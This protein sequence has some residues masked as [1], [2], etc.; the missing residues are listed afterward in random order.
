M[1]NKIVSADAAAA[2]IEDGY[3]VT[4]SGFVGIGV[5]ETLLKAVARRFESTNSP[6]HLTLFFSAGQGD[7]RDR[8]LNHL[9]ADG[10]L[11]RVI[12]GHWGL[13]PKVG[14]L[15]AEGRI[16]AYNLPQGVISQMF[17]DIAAGKPGTL[18]RVGLETFVDPRKGGGKLNDITIGDVVRLMEIDGEECLFYPAIPIDVA[19]LRGTTADTA[20]NVTMENEALTIDNLA[21]AMAAK[22]SGGMVI[23][24]V[25]QVVARG[26]LNPRDV[27]IP[28]ALV[29]AV[30]LAEPGDHMQTFRTPFSPAFT[31]RYRMP[32]EAAEAMPLDVRKVI[33]RRAAFELPVNGIV[34]LGIGMPEGVAAVAA[35]ER[36]LEHLTLTAEPG[37]IGG[38]PASGLDFGA[39]VNTDAVIAQNQQF[40]FY[41]GGGLDI[42]ILGMAEV[43]ARGS[44]NVSKFGPRLAGAGGF[45][46]ISQNARKVVFTGSFTS[47]AL[48]LSVENGALSIRSEGKVGKFVEQ[49]QHETFSGPRSARL[50]QPVLFVT[51][52]AVFRLGESGLDLIEVAP[53]VDLER[54]ILGHMEF[55]PGLENVIE[56]DGRIFRDEPMALDVDLLALDLDARIALAAD[57]QQLF[58]N[59]EKLRIRNAADVARIIARVEAICGPLDHKVDAIVNYDGTTI[60]PEIEEDY[61]SAVQRLEDTFYRST[62]RYSGSA[63]LRMKLGKSFGRS[64]N[65]HIFESAEDARRFL[66]QA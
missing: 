25:E 14:K 8:E 33:A 22:N 50:G 51:E 11:S 42:A 32:A 4:T 20:G 44:V 27:E 39:A 55:V 57:R 47:V 2:L 41:D 3:T 16:E 15:A 62:T 5:P 23:V 45:I 9:S 18:S 26:A 37:V 59:L 61:V 56:M 65:A 12:G 63:F 34:N 60:Y 6:R 49:I 48:D 40:D 21:Q 64:K 7:G 66:D 58:I 19:L 17:R 10:L 30:V 13:I 28:G 35:E 1:P 53:G 43:D 24:Q 31:G 54:D 36:L 38:Q 52:R 46:N 29:D